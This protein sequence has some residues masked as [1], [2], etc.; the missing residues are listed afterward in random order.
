VTTTRKI[1][2]V[3]KTLACCIV[4]NPDDI[5]HKLGIDPKEGA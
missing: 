3:K 1:E 4:R 2:E 5:A